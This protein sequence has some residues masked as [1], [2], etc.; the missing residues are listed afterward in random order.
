MNK[1]TTKE[2]REWIVLYLGDELSS[3]KQQW[4]EKM[5]LED[6]SWRSAYQ[7][8]QKLDSLF[9]MVEKPEVEDTPFPELRREILGRI[10]HQRRPVLLILNFVK[11]Q[12]AT[13]KDHGVHPVLAGG[14]ATLALVIGLVIN[15]LPQAGTPLTQQGAADPS[16]PPESRLFNSLV[17]KGTDYQMKR[18]KADE[19][20][21][22]KVSFDFEAP[23]EDMEMIVS[24]DNAVVQDY[25]IHL[26]KNSKNPNHRRK[27]LK[28]LENY[29][30]VDQVEEALITTMLTDMDDGV[31]LKAMQAL[32]DNK[33]THNLQEAYIRVLM[34]DQNARMR[35]DAA[36]RL[37]TIMDKELL[38]VYEYQVQVEENAYVSQ[39][40]KQNIARLRADTGGGNLQ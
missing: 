20:D 2:I 28:I 26:L 19:N 40:L 13:L 16:L 34:S 23:S 32:K 18:M 30:E 39:I 14:L 37:G 7:A 4:V 22:G 36:K 9:S 21:P 6:E 27:S 38:P 24:P 25:L 35:T 5:M 8:Q 31:R 3:E 12:W 17:E 33:I 29:Q 11:N 15:G 1:M 10:S